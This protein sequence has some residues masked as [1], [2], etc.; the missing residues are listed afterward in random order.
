[1]APPSNKALATPPPPADALIREGGAILKFGGQESEFL[2][3][4]TEEFRYRAARLDLHEKK[5][6]LF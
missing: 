2:R 4:R 1:M 5:A 6:F 3:E